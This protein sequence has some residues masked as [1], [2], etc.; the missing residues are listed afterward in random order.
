VA[1]ARFLVQ[2]D[3]VGLKR[4]RRHISTIDSPPA[5]EGLPV[6]AAVLMWVFSYC[7]LG[8]EKGTL[9]EVIAARD[10]GASKPEVVDLFR[11]AGYV[12]GPLALNA[13]AALTADYLDEWTDTEAEGLPWPVGWRPDAAAFAAGLDASTDELTAVELGRIDDWHRR[14][15]GEPSPHIGVVA[16]WHGNALKT[17][18]LRYEAAMGSTWLPARLL[19]LLLLHVEALRGR[20]RPMRR[21]ARLARHVG[22]EPQQVLGTVLWASVYGGDA[23]LEPALLAIGDLLDD[24]PPDA[25]VT[26]RG[27]PSGSRGRTP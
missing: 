13:A 27:V 11:L 23:V 19:P 8:N 17:M 5:G 12:G 26:R 14:V 18:R 16:A 4:L 6:G 3:P 7:V 22:C 20:E 9:Y 2:H 10:L 15:Y 21:A 24:Q 25:A 1:F